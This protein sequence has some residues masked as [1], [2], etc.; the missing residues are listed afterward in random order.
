M[1]GNNEWAGPNEGVLPGLDY[2]RSLSAF[3]CEEPHE[4]K[5]ATGREAAG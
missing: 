4:E 3:A 5:R 1:A 2:A